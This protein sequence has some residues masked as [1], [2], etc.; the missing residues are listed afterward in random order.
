MLVVGPALSNANDSLLVCLSACCR[1]SAIQ[2]SCQRW[3][4]DVSEDF[5]D[6]SKRVGAG[7]NTVMSIF[8]IANL[9]SANVYQIKRKK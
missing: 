1:S 8:R 2:R 7:M 6:K 5:G 9:F 3:N 4:Y